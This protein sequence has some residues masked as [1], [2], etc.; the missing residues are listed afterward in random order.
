MQV[1]T[2][3]ELPDI[4]KLFDFLKSE[5]ITERKLV[6]D[7]VSRQGIGLTPNLPSI[8]RIKFELATFFLMTNTTPA[9]IKLFAKRMGAAWRAKKHR[10][11]KA[12][13]TLSIS[14]NRDVSNQLTQMC[15]GHKKTDIVTYLITGNYPRFLAEQRAT[16]EKLAEEKRVRKVEAEKA[17]LC[18]LMKSS[19]QPAA[20]PE[21][22][23]TPSLAHLD[24]LRN[25]I[26]K[27]YEIIFTANE[28]GQIIDD[29]KLIEATKLYYS[30][31]SK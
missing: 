1:N 19:T 15:K 8:E 27:L 24:E 3:I 22:Q 11:N 16:Q 29:K 2:P 12:L 4:I 14:L 9:A 6:Q 25:G 17:N 5:T 18:K 31:F 20:K 10:K 21:Q 23:I 13:V 28:Q 7:Y 26:A 30:A